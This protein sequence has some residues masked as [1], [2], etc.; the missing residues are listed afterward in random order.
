[1]LIRPRGPVPVAALEWRIRED[2]PTNLLAVRAAAE[3]LEPAAAV[4]PTADIIAR[5]ASSPIFISI[6]S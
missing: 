6:F 3:R 5:A 1:M 4:E 2:V